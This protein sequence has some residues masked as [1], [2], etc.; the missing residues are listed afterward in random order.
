M[1]RALVRRCTASYTHRGGDL[2]AGVYLAALPSTSLPTH[3]MGTWTVAVNRSCWLCSGNEKGC[4]VVF[5][6]F[7]NEVPY[8]S[9]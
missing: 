3:M 5:L 8:V 9:S 2:Q 1:L 6:V 7:L 4:Y